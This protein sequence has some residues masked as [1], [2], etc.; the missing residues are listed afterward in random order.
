MTQHA[1]V[2]IV[3]NLTRDPELRFTQG[4]T[5][6][7]NFGIAANRRWPKNDDWQEEVSFFDCTAWAELGEN[8]ANSLSKGD[9]V[10]VNGR[11]Q[12]RSWETEDGE[13]RS[14]VEVVAD[15]VGASL[16]WA[17]ASITKTHGGPRSANEDTSSTSDD[18]G[19]DP[20]EEPF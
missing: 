15:D 4:G 14:K 10:V 13:R 18:D 16:R 8:L 17:T 19:Y 9:R 12:Q 1:E 11:L 6:V 5:A 3:G 20:A 7:T 2:T